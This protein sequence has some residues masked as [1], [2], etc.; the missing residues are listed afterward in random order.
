[1][2]SPKEA[3]KA[4][5]AAYQKVIEEAAKVVAEAP[6]NAAVN[7]AAEVAWRSQVGQVSQWL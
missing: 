1:M 6:A 3:S 2:V 7:T 4:R 5:V